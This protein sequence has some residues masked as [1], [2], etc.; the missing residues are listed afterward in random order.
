MVETEAPQQTGRGLAW[1]RG[2]RGQRR[3][4]SRDGPQKA[5]CPAMGGPVPGNLTG[6]QMNSIFLN[7]FSLL[8]VLSGD[9]LSVT[10]NQVLV[11]VICLLSNSCYPIHCYE[12]PLGNL[13]V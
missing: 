11:G 13:S 8:Q 6:R 7:L 2:M 1:G 10:R 4:G 5:A 12:M 3:E 9:S